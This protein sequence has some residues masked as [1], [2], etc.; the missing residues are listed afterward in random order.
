MELVYYLKVIQL[1]KDSRVCSVFLPI[2]SLII[3]KSVAFI[4][5]VNPTLFCIMHL[6]YFEMPIDWQLDQY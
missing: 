3:Y 1:N 6:S 2:E 4:F 5:I